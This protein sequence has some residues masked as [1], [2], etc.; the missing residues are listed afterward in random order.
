MIT[1]SKENEAIIFRFEDNQHYLQNGKIECPVNSLSLIIDESDMV[2]IRKAASNDILIS[3]TIDEFGMTKAELEEWFKVN[4]YAAG[5]GS[6]IVEVYVG[7]VNDWVDPNTG[8]VH[9]EEG[10]KEY[11]CVVY[12]NDQGQYS[13]TKV[14][15]TEFIL[16]NEFESGVT[17]T[18]DGIVQGV[19]DPTQDK[20]IIT[21]TSSGTSAETA[22][23]LSVGE[24]GFSQS[25]IQLAIDAKA[26]IMRKL[27]DPVRGDY[28]PSAQTINIASQLNGELYKVKLSGD[29][30]LSSGST[31][32][33][34]N[35]AVTAAI[36][37]RALWISAVTSGSV[38]SATSGVTLEYFNR[39]GDTLFE[40]ILPPEKTLSGISGVYVA[41]G[42][43]QNIVSGVVDSGSSVV[44]T[45]WN[46]DGTS[47]T[48]G[49]VLSV[50][51][52]G[53]RTD[54][55]Q[56][57]IDA[58]HGNTI[59]LNGYVSG[60]TEDLFGILATDTITQA[61]KK[62]E[63][64]LYQDDDTGLIFNENSD[65]TIILSAGTF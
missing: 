16:E 2:T 34:Q 52:D 42:E 26:D 1:L 47:A 8:E 48:T 51:I 28:V 49:N 18:D 61:F 27:Y 58:K 35:S 46:D 7:T 23:V 14:S 15:L 22:D 60:V 9:K 3:G 59:K 65:Q 37:D 19:V 32:F 5:G 53:F 38:V 4:A 39:S 21:Y 30:E 36:D 12:K 40:L 45:H 54:N 41:S 17:V 24:S 44:I 64:K 20:V 11:L 33:V 62:V 43:A 29:T 6:S 55:I 25:N 10:K 56:E 63:D 31:N 50:N 57:A 13:M